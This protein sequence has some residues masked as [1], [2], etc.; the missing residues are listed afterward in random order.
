METAPLEA[1][2]RAGFGGLYYEKLGDAHC[3]QVNGVELREMRLV[4]WKQAGGDWPTVLVVYKGPFEKVI[5][6]DG[7]TYRRGAPVAAWRQAER[8]RQGP[9]AGQFTFL[10]ANR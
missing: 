10:A 3:F 1:L 5:D 8:L 2:R 7:V 9:A 6:E 4:G